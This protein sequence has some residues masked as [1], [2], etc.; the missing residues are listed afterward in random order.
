MKLEAGTGGWF[1]GAPG[2]RSRPAET[3]T[4]SGD[5]IPESECVL[6]IAFFF[7]TVRA[8]LHPWLNRGPHGL[9]GHFRPLRRGARVGNGKVFDVCSS[10]G[11]AVIQDGL[12]PRGRQWP[13]ARNGIRRAYPR[14]CARR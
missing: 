8:D 4:E 5:E 6:L 10:A 11:V 3:S 7:Q 1:S 14:F 12:S 13:S 2:L 9:S